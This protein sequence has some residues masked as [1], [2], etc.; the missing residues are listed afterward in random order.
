MGSLLVELAERDQ[1]QA[2]F[3]VL[4]ID[5]GAVVFAQNLRHRHVAAGGRAAKL[6][7]IGGRRIL[8]LEEAMQERGMRWVDADLERLQ[9][10]AAHVALECEGVAIR[11]DKT[12][13][14][15]K[16]RRLAFAEIGPE[17]SALLNHG[18]SALRDV[19]AQRRILRLRRRF[20]ALARDVVQ[21]AM[22]STTQAAV[23]QAAE[24]KVGAA[25]RAMALDQAVTSLLIA[26]QHQ[27]LAEHF[28]GFY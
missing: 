14:L 1:P 6:L 5:D 23:F 20:K 13:D 7:A 21:P 17:D 28:D 22:K 25:M 16:G 11:R 19:L 9:P 3:G 15:R 18:V 27:I 8:V 10:V 12:V 2:V 26:K 4:D 24:G